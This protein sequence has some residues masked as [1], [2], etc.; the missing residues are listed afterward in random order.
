[1]AND[2]KDKNESGKDPSKTQKQAESKPAEVNLDPFAHPLVPSRC[3]G[4]FPAGTRT[5]RRTLRENAKNFSLKK[6]LVSK[7]TRVLSPFRFPPAA[8]RL[9]SPAL[10]PLVMTGRNSISG[11][12]A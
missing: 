10:A 7:L 6:P 12:L 1:M 2:P 11:F 4:A 5:L 8:L 9:R 3:I